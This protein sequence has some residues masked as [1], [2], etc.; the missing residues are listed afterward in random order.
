MCS[1]SVAIGYRARGHSA[2]PHG[3]A[4]LASPRL[5]TLASHA[6]YT[7][8]GWLSACAAS[9]WPPAPRSIRRQSALITGTELLAPVPVQLLCQLVRPVDAHPRS[10]ELADPAR[11][12]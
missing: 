3:R 6:A 2:G 10:L 7:S 5:L 11:S 8:S 1:T 4:S 9:N 12:L